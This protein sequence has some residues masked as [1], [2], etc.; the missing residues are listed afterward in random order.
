[1]YDFV[2]VPLLAVLPVRRTVFVF[3]PL[4]GRGLGF[5]SANPRGLAFST[6]NEIGLLRNPTPKASPASWS[7][8]ES[9][10]DGED[11]AYPTRQ[12]L[13]VRSSRMI[14]KYYFSPFVRR[15]LCA[16]NVG[17][18]S[19]SDL[20][21]N[22]KSITFLFSGGEMLHPNPNKNPPPNHRFADAPKGAYGTQVKKNS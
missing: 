6:R 18:T 10:F 12:N 3:W 11:C 5:A 15:R 17:K 22:L 1:M 19:W 8:K 2:W 20:P 14:E 16:P 13:V 7:G 9:F 21:E 4:R